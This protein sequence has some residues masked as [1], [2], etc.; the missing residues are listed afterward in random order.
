MPTCTACSAKLPLHDFS[1]AQLSGRGKCLRCS[2]P[3]LHALKLAEGLEGEALT[4]GLTTAALS[5]DEDDGASQKPPA[6]RKAKSGGKAAA[7]AVKTK[8]AAAP[9]PAV[10]MDDILID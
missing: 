1:D 4:A 5:G 3:R 9:K 7:A 8:T 6:A 10:N 2:N